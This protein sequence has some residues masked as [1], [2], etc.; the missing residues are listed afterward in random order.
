MNNI[1]A[2]KYLSNNHGSLEL[3]YVGLVNQKFNKRFAGYTPLELLQIEAAF[4]KGC[5]YSLPLHH[6]GFRPKNPTDKDL[7]FDGLCAV[8]EFLCKLDNIENAMDYSA[9]LDYSPKVFSTL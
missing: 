2:W 9:L 6:K 1:D 8:I 4:L 3:N 5:G 7:L